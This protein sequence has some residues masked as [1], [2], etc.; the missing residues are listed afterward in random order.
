MGSSRPHPPPEGRAATRVA[1]AVVRLRW[2]IIAVWTAAGLLATLR[3]PNAAGALGA[4]SAAPPGTESARGDALLDA[5]FARP[6]SEV[7]AVTLESPLPVDAPPA[8]AV[9]DSVV[10]TLGRQRY[11]GRVVT[12]RSGDSTLLRADRR[13]TA[14]FL[15]VEPP[16][17]VDAD[18]LV[19]PARAAIHATLASI[20]A[21]TARYRVH[22]TGSAALDEDLRVVSEEDSR[23]SEL[24]LAPLTLAVLVLSFGA[25]VAASLPLVV[26]FLAVW[27]SLAAIA[28][29]AAVTPIS[30][31]VMSIMTML[32]LGVG[33]DYSLLVVNRFREE[34][35][36]RPPHEA[37]ATAAATAGAAVVTSGLTVL[38]GFAA[39]LLTPIVETRSIGIGG[40][41]VVGVAVALATTLLPALLAILGPRIDWPGWLARRLAWYHAREPWRR[42]ARMIIAHPGR[43]LFAGTLLIGAVA[44]PAL[45]MR[46]GLPA[47]H[48]WPAGTESA[49]GA[50][51]LDR[52]GL[53]AVTQPIQVLVEL[54]AGARATSPEML[55]ALQRLGDTLAAN[56][57]V[58]QVRSIAHPGPVRDVRTLAALY[59]D[60]RG[61]GAPL[62]ELRDA[63]L[64]TDGRVALMDVVLRDSVSLTSATGV[65]SEVRRRA[66]A[67]TGE[68]AGATTHVTGFF[69]E[70]ADLQRMLLDQLPLLAGL[71]LSVTV[72]MLALAFRSVL[73]PVKAVVVNLLPVAGSFGLIVWVFQQGHGARLFGLTGPTE[74]IF[75]VVPVLVFAITFG[76]SMDYEVF[77]LA[78][79]KEEYDRTGRN[80]LAIENGLSATAPTITS[81]ALIMIL[82]F[83][84]FAFARVFVVQ[85]LGFGLAAAVLLDATLV[86][87]VIVP[88]FMQLAGRWN[89]WPGG[90]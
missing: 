32:G 63:Y 46:I 81:A 74:A 4:A 77:L 60:P 52:L 15:P 47:R 75:G 45:G 61:D 53:G 43:A 66:R 37:A 69:A 49:R 56:P 85:V 76:L 87:L 18:E 24:R 41:I 71:I 22:V 86:R 54:P 42:W 83:G 14:I 38:V 44:L 20:G 72:V 67:P 25:L 57:R 65:V 70:S 51:A 3:A 36:R 2:A 17:G 88:A 31:Y 13:A 59:A 50:A 80:D 9:L 89:W 78:R 90:R 39:L 64:S 29:L 40:M 79:I 10:A 7:L 6:P 48:W 23:R 62:A 68:L 82:V 19:E 28:L 34:S 1:R 73:V 11:A 27:I 35:E 84:A 21:D 5:R 55:A 26:G 33:I 16:R 58:R 12:W 30:V 8:A